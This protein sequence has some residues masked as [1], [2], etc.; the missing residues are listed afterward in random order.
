[1]II[2]IVERAPGY[3]E[4]HILIGSLLSIHNLQVEKSYKANG[5]NWFAP[6]KQTFF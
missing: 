2:I 3:E 4:V 1:M 6:F 5:E